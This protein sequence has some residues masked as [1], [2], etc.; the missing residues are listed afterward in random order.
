MLIYKIEDY[1]NLREKIREERVRENEIEPV[2]LDFYDGLRNSTEGAYDD[3]G[4]SFEDTTG[5]FDDDN[6]REDSQDIYKKFNGMKL[7]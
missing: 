3:G 5:R 2:I 4:P 6:S 1:K 7:I